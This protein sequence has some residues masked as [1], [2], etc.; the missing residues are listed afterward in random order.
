MSV[1]RE[2]EP[3]RSGMT[4]Y[5]S[6]QATVLERVES[7]CSVCRGIKLGKMSI[8]P[9]YKNAPRSRLGSIPDRFSIEVLSNALGHN[10]PGTQEDTLPDLHLEIDLAV[11]PIN[12]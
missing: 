2:S 7:I 12:Q 10:F 1:C 8:W 3:T 9:R 5:F 11:L 6:P 4:Q